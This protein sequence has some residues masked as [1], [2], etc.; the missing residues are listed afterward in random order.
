MKTSGGSVCH[1]NLEI[2]S[3]WLVERQIG[4]V[5]NKCILYLIV[6]QL[7]AAAVFGSPGDLYQTDFGSGSVFR[8]TPAGAKT[9]FA[10]GLGNPAGLAFDSEGNLFV[11]DNN[12]NSITKITPS[13]ARSTFATGLGQPFGLA[14]DINGNLYEADEG[15]GHVFKFTPTGVKTTFATGLSSPAG[16]AFDPSGNLFVSNFMAARIDKITT[17]GVRTTFATGLSFPDGLYFSSSGNLLECDSGSGKIFSFTEAGART[18]F[19]SGFVQ[20][21]GVIMDAAGNAYVTQNAA[22]TITKISPGGVRTTFAAGLFNPQYLAFEPAPS[23]PPVVTTNPATFIAAFSATLNGSLNAHGLPT[24][25]HFRYGTTTNYGLTTAPQS[26]TGNASR[27][28]SANINTLTAS[29]TYHFRV[30][31]SN[32]AGT[33][34]GGD[35]TFTTLTVTGLPIVTTNPATNVTASSAI[36]HGS[37]DPHGLTTTIQFQYGR[38]NIYGHLT[39]SQTQ[40]G[41]MYRSIAANIAG[42][43]AHT[44]YHFR[45]VGTNSGGTRM[46]SDRTFTTP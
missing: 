38:T 3:H 20:N 45:V 25:F 40:T 7:L 32:M 22:G 26:Q 29:T 27:P 30:V 35:K 12:G 39:A 1:S 5:T 2:A 15:S 19:A 4:L 16:L 44:T 24:T 17:N 11:A 46:G 28:V 41:N 36:L 34:M 37:L 6:A 10:T 13:G 21:S 14:F 43:T 18:T 9:T 8:Y 31:A 33:R 42:L 23:G